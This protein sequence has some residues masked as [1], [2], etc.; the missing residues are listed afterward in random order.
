MSFVAFSDC[1]DPRVLRFLKELFC[2]FGNYVPFMEAQ[3]KSIAIFGHSILSLLGEDEKKR[4]EDSYPS[5][6]IYILEDGNI[7]LFSL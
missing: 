2:Q 3:K 4:W 6:R 1:E 5:D 7:H